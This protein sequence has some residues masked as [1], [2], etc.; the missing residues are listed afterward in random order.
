[1]LQGYKAQDNFKHKIREI[2]QIQLT[3]VGSQIKSK[4]DHKDT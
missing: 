4:S 2:P 1:M 3:K